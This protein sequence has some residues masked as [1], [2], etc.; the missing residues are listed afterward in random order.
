ME[1]EVLPDPAAVANRAADIVQAEID[2]Y[3]GILLGLAG[4]S[5]PRST[6][7]TLTRRSIDWSYTTAWMTDERWVAPDDDESNQKM[8]RASLVDPTG[9]AFLAPDTTADSI[10]QAAVDFSAVIM[11]AV[12]RAN[13][14][15]VLLGI[16]TDGHTASLFPGSPALG[17]AGVRYVEN[18]VE[19]L[20]AWRL[21]ATF[22]LLGTAD[23]VIF[24]VTGAS[25]ADMI[26]SIAG[27][28]D[29]PSARVTARQQVLWLL[30]EA[31]AS[32]FALTT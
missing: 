22:D 9:L 2:S 23:I 1:Y 10:E 30:D 20:G 25:K 27:G 17:D 7:E 12:E 28:A 19:T 8:A 11:R 24:L 6:Y 13:R 21:T 3:G 18:Y 4:G 16:G 5:T 26:A 32:G 14:S 29:V 15:V 31:A